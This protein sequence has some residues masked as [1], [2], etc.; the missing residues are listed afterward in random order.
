M[1]LYSAPG[2]AAGGTQLFNFRNSPLAY[3]YA[4]TI[5]QRLS[6]AFPDWLGC[7]LSA[8]ACLP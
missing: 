4:R 2:Y 8:W 1:Q 7:A 5:G 3:T 6:H